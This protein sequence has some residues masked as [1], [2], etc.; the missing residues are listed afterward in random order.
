MLRGRHQQLG[1]DKQG[2]LRV[3]RQQLRLGSWAMLRRL[4]I[5]IRPKDVQVREQGPS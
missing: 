2:V 5:G 3:R 1:W 4:H